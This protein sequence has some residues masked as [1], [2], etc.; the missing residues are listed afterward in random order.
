[1]IKNVQYKKNVEE[2]CNTCHNH[3]KVDRHI[4]LKRLINKKSS[5]YTD[6]IIN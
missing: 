4:L 6:E 5:S 3:M 2:Y 1:M